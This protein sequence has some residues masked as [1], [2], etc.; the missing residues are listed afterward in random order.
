[1]SMTL[2]AL[3]LYTLIKCVRNQQQWRYAGRVPMTAL[4]RKRCTV[5]A[6]YMRQLVRSAPLRA[7]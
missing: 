4:K 5:A 7:D 3:L 2:M 6:D 1:M